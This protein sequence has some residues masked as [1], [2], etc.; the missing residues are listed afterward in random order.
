MKYESMSIYSCI[1]KV[2]ETLFLPDIQRPYVWD[3][4][5]VYL[6]FDS[7]CRNYPFNTVL[8]WAIE[9]KTLA[10][11]KNIKRVNFITQ[12]W[13]E[14]EINTSSLDRDSYY[15]AIDGQQR[16][17][18]LFLSLKGNYMIKVRRQE[19]LA[20]IY[21]NFLSGFEENEKE[22]LYEFQFFPQTKDDVFIEEIR[23][24]TTKNWIRL[25]SI[26]A[27]N[28]LYEVQTKLKEKIKDEINVDVSDKQ[29]N[30]LFRIWSKIRHE[31]LIA[32]YEEKT[33]DY[34]KV[35]DIFVRTNSG[36]QKL[37]YSDLLF[38]YIKLNWTNSRDKFS[39][40]LKLLNNN[41]IFKFSNDFLLKT[42]LF[43]YAT[44]QE[45]LK[46]RTSNFSKEIVD[47]IAE[48]WDS[49]LSDAF[50]LTKDILVSRF[51]LTNDKLITSYNAIIPIVYFIYKHN[52]KGIGEESN[53]ITHEIQASMQE[54]LITSMLTGV[55]GGQSDGV[56]Y[57]AKT[58]ID[59]S[60]RADYFP[61]TELF[62]K[63]NEAKPALNLNIT[64]DLISKESYN[65]KNSSLIL[66]LL[67]K[68]AVNFSPL[69]DDN[70]P[71]QDHIIPRNELKKFGI[72]KEDINSIFNLRFVSASDNRIKSDEP[73]SEWFERVGEIIGKESLLKN[74]TIPSGDWS[75]NNYQL[76]LGARKKLFMAELLG[77]K[78]NDSNL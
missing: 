57:R 59:D 38:S 3:E 10:E 29:N 35:L 53:K 49:K 66:S 61:M 32:Y 40:L 44:D 7:I 36:G 60:S 31:N 27:I 70:K 39:S 56:L 11:N 22:M 30:N 45:S 78:K 21:F 42:M 73:Y 13:K 69:L 68:N 18:S 20:D 12:R 63:F 25:K 55:F 24:K 47:N 2:N 16:I 41:E 58:A 1:E 48:Q 15:L 72:S 76:F 71:Q 4:D 6:L 23:D 34:D 74:H 64:E 33:Q 77:T 67:Y 26:I 50:K 62:V 51:L 5:D 14:N 17:T 43:I 75:P 54:W 28:D 46:Y 52:K 19:E 8:F 65:S 37:S 9:K